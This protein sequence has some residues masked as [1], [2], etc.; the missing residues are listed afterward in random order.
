MTQHFEV[1]PV[2]QPPNRSFWWGLAFRGISVHL[3]IFVYVSPISEFRGNLRFECH[4][5]EAKINLQY[6]FHVHST[7]VLILLSTE[8][9]L[10]TY[11]ESG[12][13]PL[14]GVTP[15]IFVSIVSHAS[16]FV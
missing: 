4:E 5:A 1:F 8:R 9:N 16:L 12:V 2:F 10:K 14:R 13:V 6:Y 11:F 3:N 7:W 15:S